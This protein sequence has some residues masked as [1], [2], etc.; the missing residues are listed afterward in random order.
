MSFKERQKENVRV[1]TINVWYY[2]NI[3]KK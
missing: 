2:T 3:V 1:K